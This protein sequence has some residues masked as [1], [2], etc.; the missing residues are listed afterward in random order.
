[1]I[2]RRAL[3]RMAA[4]TLTSLVIA[5]SLTAGC[6]GDDEETSGACTASPAGSLAFGVACCADAECSTG[7]C[8]S[9]M[10]KGN[11]CTKEC[12]GGDADCLMTDGT[13]LGCGGQGLC[14]VP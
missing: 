10:Q 12:P 1:M 4:A 2:V 3:R 11:R 5:L 13:N 7:K 8:G 9:F 14:K 6:G